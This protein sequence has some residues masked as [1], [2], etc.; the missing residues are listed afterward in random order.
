LQTKTF[1][2]LWHDVYFIFNTSRS[3]TGIMTDSQHEN[4]CLVTSLRLAC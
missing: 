2:P 3:I 1:N 4:T